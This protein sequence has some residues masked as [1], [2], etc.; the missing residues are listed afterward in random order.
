MKEQEEAVLVFERDTFKAVIMTQKECN[1]F[2]RMPEASDYLLIVMGDNLIEHR[3]K[4]EGLNWYLNI[5]G[6]SE[7]IQTGP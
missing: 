5:S 1:Y 4:C 7:R 2:P 3:C 6:L